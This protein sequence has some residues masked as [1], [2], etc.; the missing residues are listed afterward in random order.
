M[1]LGTLLLVDGS[2]ILDI[3]EQRELRAA[4]NLYFGHSCPQR[5][6]L[7]KNRLWNALNDYLQF[8]IDYLTS[9]LG[10]KTPTPDEVAPSLF[11]V[12]FDNLQQYQKFLKVAIYAAREYA[13]D[14]KPRLKRTELDTYEELI[15]TIESDFENLILDYEQ[16]IKKENRNARHTIG[17][18]DRHLIYDGKWA[19]QSM[20]FIEH[21]LSSRKPDF[22]GIRPYSLF[23]DRQCLEIAGN[24]LLGFYKIIDQRGNDIHKFTQVGWKFL[25]VRNI[26]SVGEKGW[27]VDL[28]YQ[29]ETIRALV[30]WSNS[31]VH[32]MRFYTCYIQH[33]AM[34]MMWR[35]LQ[36]AGQV[37]TAIGTKWDSEHGAFYI[38][39]YRNLKRDFEHYVKE[40]NGNKSATIVWKPLN[41][42]GAYIRS[43][44]P[45]R[46]LYAMH[47]PPPVHGASMVG[48]YI[49]DSKLL[50]DRF[51]GEYINLT[52][53]ANLNDIGRIG[54]KK[55]IG[56]VRMLLKIRKSIMTGKPHVIYLTPNAAGK[57]FYKDFI[58][59][60]L[61]KRW[62]G[63]SLF[64]YKWP[65]KIVWNWRK[66]KIVK[67]KVRKP[68]I[69][70]HY[71][72]KGVKNFSK[73]K[74]NDWLYRKFF[75]D[76]YVL[77][78]SEV[79]YEDV[80]K[81]VPA[82]RVGFCGNG[83]PALS[84]E[85]CKKI[86]DNVRLKY[87]DK[88]AK[89]IHVLY[90]SNMMEEKGV[91]TLVDACKI[92][93]DKGMDF[94]CT[95]VGGWKDITEEMFNQRISSLGLHANVIAVGPKYGA[96]K[97]QY[98]MDAD[99]LVFPTYYHNECFPL[100]LLEAMQH[101]L[102]CISTKEGAIPDIIDDGVSGFVVNA[103]NS[104]HLAVKITELAND[105]AKRLDMGVEGYRK[106][107]ERFTL[108][109][110]EN[111]ICEVLEQLM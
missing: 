70:V 100:V 72:N 36:P 41:N 46:V 26:V 79:L 6:A 4:Y 62:A 33:Y 109:V 80:K 2:E 73:S 92:L 29:V 87:A 106:F 90:L 83:L 53:A 71:H 65:F 110:F 69:L 3:P 96:D 40:E 14:L 76:L 54:L 82:S 58:T 89:P 49:R 23:I 63:Y 59:V 102:P 107:C 78:L 17:S 55:V 85:I 64:E 19:A 22:R 103:K 105:K 81:Y 98:W 47:M 13:A 7:T 93:K 50:Q 43:L 51:D 9:E 75:K 21:E 30:S 91:W 84:N 8:C 11:V 56:Y 99:V 24:N 42:V 38:E 111:R 34:D 57:P 101:A 95:F 5:N 15:L 61:V 1:N 37:K 25:A 77:L 10:G 18:R 48:Q 20:V 68:N 44:G 35:I 16:L 104:G 60:C 39:N 94:R 32:K 74:L 27:S 28:P 31:F 12:E 108:N 45:G 66:R 86:S 88:T 67:K 52:A 97:E